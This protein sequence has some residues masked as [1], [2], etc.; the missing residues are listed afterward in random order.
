M[1]PVYSVVIPTHNR[2]DVLPETLLALERQQGAPEF[3]TVIV[4]DGSTDG[5]RD[6]LDTHRS[7]RPLRVLH[8][9][10]G[11]PARAR[12]AGVGAASGRYVAF[13]G[14]DTVPEPDWLAQHAR[15]RTRFDPE[16]TAVVGY[17]R[18]HRRMRVT[19]LLDFLNE[20][21]LQ[22]GYALIKDPDQVP[23]NFFYT[24]NLSLPRALLLREPFDH[25]FPYPAF[26]DIDAGYRMMRNHRMRLVYAAEAIVQHDHPTTYR[27]FAR[28]QEHAGY[29]GVLF[30]RLYPELGEMLGVSRGKLPASPAAWAQSLRERV[31]EALERTPIRL[32]RTWCRAFHYHYIKGM[33]RAWSELAMDQAKVSPPNSTPMSR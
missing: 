23:F 3:E 27:R 9:A 1:T 19:P 2:I 4:N 10:N 18:W 29:S 28:R 17:T 31:I 15:A 16:L 20:K 24:S 32:E 30:Y 22:F 14:D 7:A 11:G 12:N 25:R 8:Q 21:G 26:E 13:L 6:F 5:T 33:R